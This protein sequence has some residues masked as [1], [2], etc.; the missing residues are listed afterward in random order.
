MTQKIIRFLYF[1][2]LLISNIAKAEE[3]IAGDSTQKKYHISGAVAV[4]Q[5]GF[6]ILPMFTLG[7][8]AAI[9]DLSVGSDRLAF[10]P[11]FRF[12]LEGRPWSFIFWFRYKAVNQKKF[13]FSIGGHPSVAFRNTT[14][15]D[16]MGVPKTIL[17]PQQYFA[18]EWIPS[19]QVSKKVTLGMYYLIS[20]G[21]TEGTNHRTNFV[22]INAVVNNVLL[23]KDTFLRFYP[24]IYYLDIDGVDGYYITETLTL[25]NKHIPFTISSIMNKKLSSRI[26]G[27]DFV[28]NISL[29][30]LFNKQLKRI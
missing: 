14:L 11:Q 30:Y 18:T 5:N 24:Q 27:D 3:F 21:L 20:Q 19:Y 12:S 2:F 28:W 7:K 8:P 16:N 13:K 9:F 23:A 17:N 6:S 10:E 26:P 25:S 1:V 15:Y 29:N 4:T 22:T